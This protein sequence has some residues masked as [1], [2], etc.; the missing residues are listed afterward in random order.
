MDTFDVGIVGAGVH[1][2]SVAYHL[3]LRGV[4]VVIFERW[5]AAGK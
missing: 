5:T 1:G 3:A 2:A 4:K